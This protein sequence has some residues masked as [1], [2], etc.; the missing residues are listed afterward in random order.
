MQAIDP[1]I[2]RKKFQH[3][4]DQFIALT[5]SYRRRG[6]ILLK[7]NFPEIVLSFSAVKLKPAIHSFAVLL[8]F[9]NYD[10]EP[11]SVRFVDPFT[12]ELL[13]VTPNP[14]FRKNIKT[15]GSI[16]PLALAQQDTTGLPFVCIPGVREYHNH[17]AHSGDSWLLH[18]KVDGEG[19][20]GFIIEALYRY[21]ILAID[22]FQ[23]QAMVNVNMAVPNMMLGFN[24]NLMEE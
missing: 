9:E 20:L 3:E 6:I 24:P 1:E 21:G 5:D 18:R 14:L 17:P 11:I 22:S 16:E 8:N 7:D 4:V 2:S 12:F 23:V 19:T 13:P 10:I 15:D